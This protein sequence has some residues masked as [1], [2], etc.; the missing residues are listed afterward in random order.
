MTNYTKITL[1]IHSNSSNGRLRINTK[2]CHLLAIYLYPSQQTLKL[3]AYI[4]VISSNESFNTQSLKVVGPLGGKF[5]SSVP[6]DL[7]LKAI[8]ITK[9]KKLKLYSVKAS[10]HN[11]NDKI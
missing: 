3:F 8:L 10:K 9:C 4:F 5:V 7:E 1:H 11:L 6:W 2:C